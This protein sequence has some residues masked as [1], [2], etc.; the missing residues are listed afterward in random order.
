MK[1]FLSLAAAL[2][3]LA[4]AATPASAHRGG[5]D[6]ACGDQNPAPLGAPYTNLKADNISCTGAHRVA[7]KYTEKPFT[8]GYKGWAC[9]SKP[10]GYEQL[11]VKCSRDNNGGQRLKFNWGA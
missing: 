6:L 4:I 3:V 8:D 9:D 11:K 2:V 7:T 5:Y 1:T 10:T